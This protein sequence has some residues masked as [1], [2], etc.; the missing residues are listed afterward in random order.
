MTPVIRDALDE[1]LDQERRA[2]LIRANR[3]PARALELQIA[4]L[5]PALSALQA[6]LNVERRRVL[7]LPNPLKSVNRQMVPASETDK[8]HLTTRPCGILIRYSHQRT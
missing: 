4:K 1:L 7:D 3:A 6:V 5:E 2:P 8:V